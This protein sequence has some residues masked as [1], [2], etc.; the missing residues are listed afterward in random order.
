MPSK[1]RRRPRQVKTQ[2]S[3][4]K[5]RF[6]WL[7]ILGAFFAAFLVYGFFFSG[8]F[9]I[10]HVEITG[11]RKVE[12]ERIR[13]LIQSN[14]HHFV[15]LN[16]NKLGQAL[17]NEFPGIRQVTIKK[18]PLDSLEVIVVERRGVAI[19]CPLLEV[20]VNQEEQCFALDS[21]GIMFEE[22]SPGELLFRIRFERRMK[23]ALGDKIITQETMAKLLLFHENIKRF[24]EISQYTIISEER[25]NVGISEGWDVYVAPKENIEWQTDK[26]K[27]VI[28]KNI[29]EEQRTNLEYIDLRFGDQAFI[30]YQE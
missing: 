22:R 12:T 28:E 5:N 20:Q 7:G 16:M 24:L 10:K 21:Q 13:E 29:S 1:Y 17:L 18:K 14:A 19:W 6:L 9:N 27:A 26:L 15:L 3:I 30:K 23:A 8:V 2:K 11:N 4:L 25:I